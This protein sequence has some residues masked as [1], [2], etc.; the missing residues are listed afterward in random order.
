MRMWAASL[1][2]VMLTR[3]RDGSQSDDT[4]Y[5]PRGYLY[6][7][8]YVRLRVSRTSTTLFLDYKAEQATPP[9]SGG[10]TRTNTLP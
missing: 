6:T 1:R 5:L 4:E 9:D 10:N 8:G 3:K 2:P 7:Y